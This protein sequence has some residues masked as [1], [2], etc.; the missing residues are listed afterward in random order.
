M[1]TFP[2]VILFL[3]LAT[4]A[5]AQNVSADILKKTVNRIRAL[6]SISYKVN[7]TENNPF[8]KGQVISA[9]VDA[10]VVF[11]PSG[12]VSYK[13]EFTNINS[14]QSL[15]QEI[16]LEGKY[17]SINLTDSTYTEDVPK[18]A[19]VCEMTEIATLIE[20]ELTKNGSKITHQTDTVFEGNKC[21]NFLIKSHDTVT[22]GIHDYTHR[23]ILINHK[24][25]LPVYV[26]NTTAGTAYK[27]GA[28]MLKD[29]DQ[30]P[31][32]ILKTVSG[33]D[34]PESDFN[35]K[36]LLVV[37]GATGCPANPLAN[38]MLNRM[39]ANFSSEKFIIINIYTNEMSEVVQKYIENNKLAFPVYIGNRTLSKAFKT[40]G[41]PN[42]YLISSEGKILRSFRG[43]KNSLEKDLTSH[44]T[45]LL[46]RS[47]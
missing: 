1:K 10:K 33:I 20:S 36:L 47:L 7:S 35:G 30:A 3:F 24:T 28:S 19:V 43:Y 23:Q 27:G 34:T 8:N 5:H 32:L 44:I 31:K 6:K 39:H 11:S 12:A 41:T 26:K 2:C 14:G 38:P 16:Y 40:P 17:Y 22:N 42:F 21:Y 29:G 25:L 18:S 37:F 46:E 9:T 4:F 13:K 45:K 15:F